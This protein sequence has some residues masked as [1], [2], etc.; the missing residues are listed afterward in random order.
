MNNNILFLTH[1]N[2]PTIVV[3]QAS[4]GFQLRFSL[5]DDDV[6]DVAIVIDVGMVRVED[7]NEGGGGGSGDDKAVLGVVVAILK[8]V[9]LVYLILVSLFKGRLA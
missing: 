6:V 7:D 4:K 3:L 8:K 5:E 9:I 1:L 2:P